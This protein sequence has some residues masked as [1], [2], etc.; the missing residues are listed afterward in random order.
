MSLDN[1][2]CLL[3]TRLKLSKCTHIYIQTHVVRMII[4]KAY[5]NFILNSTRIQT[6]RHPFAGCY[7]S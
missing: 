3:E 7:F 5:N 6:H 2:D 4:L 1:G